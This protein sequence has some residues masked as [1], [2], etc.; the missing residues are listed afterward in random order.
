M[1]NKSVFKINDVIMYLAVAVEHMRLMLLIM[2]LCLVAGLTYYCYA[3]PVYYSRSL[4]RVDVADDVMDNSTVFHD[5]KK[6]TVLS[7][8]E[9]GMLAQRAAKKL[10]VNVTGKELQKDWVKRIDVKNSIEGLQ[11]EV[12]PYQL[13]WAEKFPE[14]LVKEYKDFVEERR[15]QMMQDAFTSYS[16]EMENFKK[17][18][19]MDSDVK[20]SYQELSR[21]FGEVKQIP[22]ELQFIK[23]RLE[24]MDYIREKCNG[25][26]DP[27]V[28]LTFMNSL[29]DTATAKYSDLQPKIGTTISAEDSATGSDTI[30]L[31]RQLAPTSHNWQKLDREA[32][33]LEQEIAKKS[34]KYLPG[35]PE[36]RTRL[37]RLKQIGEQLDSEYNNEQ[38]SFNLEYDTMVARQHELERRLPTYDELARACEKAGQD[39]DLSRQG[40]IHLQKAM[41]SIL[42]KLNQF[43]VSEGHDRITVDYVGPLDPIS[44]EPKS[45]SR[46][47]ITA[48][49]LIAGIGLAIAI[50]FLIAYLDNSVSDVEHAEEQF[51]LRGLGVVPRVDENAIQNILISGSNNSPAAK[52]EYHL[53]ENF[54]I[55]RTNLIMHSADQNL[56]QVI[57]VTSAMPQEGKTMIAANLA[58]SFASKGEKTILVDGDLRRGRLHRMFGAQN[59]P[60]L[61]DVLSKYN[62]IADACRPTGNENLTLMTCGK[63]LN[64][65]AELLDSAGFAKI[66]QELRSQYQRVIIDSP[67]VL[68]LSETSIMQRHADG[69]VVVIWANQTQVPNVKDA[70]LALQTNGAKFS[71]FILNRLDFNA[72]ANRYKYFYYSPR[73]YSNYKAFEATPAAGIES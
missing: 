37:A 34:E 27:V 51:G 24:K 38:R 1:K 11:L 54:R 49:S 28:K 56:P 32:H 61:S 52:P 50:P 14:T 60:G 64:W 66:V 21:K 10:G 72:F 39:Y 23:T 3:R 15:I 36:I 30:I 33:T 67:P 65:A 17:K 9:S 40:G 29:P 13:S 43:D 45:P 63:H 25:T 59:K 2:C 41:E 44:S 46:M 58:M 69:V 47:R 62:T 4:I 16:A 53:L 31:P 5:G 42:R 73:Y 55:I 18:A 48:I 8:L 20:K 7:I 70:I 35:H 12:W 19:S 22:G 68:G 26:T 57:L 71:G 6:Q